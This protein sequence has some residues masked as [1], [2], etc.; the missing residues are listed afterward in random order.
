MRSLGDQS[1]VPGCIH[2]IHLCVPGQYFSCSLSIPL[3]EGFW[4]WL[5]DSQA[6][7]LFLVLLPALS[8]AVL[9]TGRACLE[10][11]E[12]YTLQKPPGHLRCPVAAHWPEGSRSARCPTVPSQVAWPLGFC[13]DILQGNMNV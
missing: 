10:P 1:P 12:D 7:L 9:S 13:L 8:A 11:A 4:S 3:V 6:T 5:L 2:F